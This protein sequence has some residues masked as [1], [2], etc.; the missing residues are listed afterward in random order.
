MWTRKEWKA[1]HPDA[2][3][4][5]K[6]KEE[7]MLRKAKIRALVRALLSSYP[8]SRLSTSTRPSTHVPYAYAYADDQYDRPYSRVTSDQTQIPAPTGDNAY[9]AQAQNQQQIP[10]PT[11]QSREVTME[12]PPSSGSGSGTNGNGNGKEDDM[13]PAGVIKKTAPAPTVFWTDHL[14]MI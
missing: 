14:R 11:V 4:V 8:C 13:P 7:D 6:Q 1:V 3:K 2:A 9:P 12:Q 10:K 5:A